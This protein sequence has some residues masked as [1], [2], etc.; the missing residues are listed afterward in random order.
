MT[1]VMHIRINV[2]TFF[3][4]FSVHFPLMETNMMW[5]VLSLLIKSWGVKDRL[6]WG[7]S[8]KDKNCS[9]LE[10]TTIHHTHDT[11]QSSGRRWR[12]WIAKN[13]LRLDVNDANDD[14]LFSQESDQFSYGSLT[15]L[16]L[17][18]PQIGYHPKELLEH[19][20]FQAEKNVWAFG[21]F[22]HLIK[23]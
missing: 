18:H 3:T 10:V 22:S 6:E 5:K 1:G 15:C 14:H 9:H 17:L 12:E 19:H 11:H 7:E 4:F 2:C 23:S 16:L 13:E 8:R 21:L 20:E